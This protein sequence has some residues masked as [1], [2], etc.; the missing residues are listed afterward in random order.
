MWIKIRE[1]NRSVTRK[2]DDY[3]EKYMKNKFNSDDN[4]S[5]NKI[6]EICIMAVVVRVVFLKNNKYYQQ[7]FL[8]ECLYKIWMKSKNELKKMILKIVC[9]F[10]LLR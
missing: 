8:D 5:L 7:V 10:I 3:D 2:L 4:V 6:I 9:S 1:L